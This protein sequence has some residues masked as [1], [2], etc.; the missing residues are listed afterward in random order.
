M[1]NSL[2]AAS[3][4]KVSALSVLGC[5]SHL[6]SSGGGPS[7]KGTGAQVV[8]KGWTASAG[9]SVPVTLQASL[10]GRGLCAI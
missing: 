2:L 10:A 9:E 7:S 4:K 1:L 8:D 3:N 5:I 6:G